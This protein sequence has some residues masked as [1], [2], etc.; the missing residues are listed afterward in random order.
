VTWI[1]RLVVISTSSKKC[2][3]RSPARQE[4]ALKK[5]KQK[6]RNWPLILET[7][8]NCNGSIQ[9]KLEAGSKP[10]IGSLDQQFT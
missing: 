10:S 5:A 2:Q 8:G 4:L 6:D 9:E 7:V 3:V 1:D